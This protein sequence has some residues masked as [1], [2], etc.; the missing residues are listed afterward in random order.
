MR[1]SEEPEMMRQEKR[2]TRWPVQSDWDI[3][4]VPKIDQLLPEEGNPDAI[5][6]PKGKTEGW[7]SMISASAD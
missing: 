1:S 6:V 7:Q 2:L 4:A 5:P 3:R